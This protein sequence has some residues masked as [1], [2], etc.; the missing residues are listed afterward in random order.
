MGRQSVP[1]DQ[2]PAPGTPAI[3]NW[4]VGDHFGPGNA[5][6]SANYNQNGYNLNASA[7]GINGF[8]VVDGFGTSQSGNYIARRFYPAISG[9]SNVQET[10]GA[11][12]PYVTIEWFYAAN[13]IQ[14]A[15]NTDLSA[16]V[17][18]AWAFGT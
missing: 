17:V 8:E 4:W 7:L 14:V 9:N 12:F 18:R 11:T 16:E 6:G 15:N 13:N 2:Y 1:C 10:R 3:K 5:G